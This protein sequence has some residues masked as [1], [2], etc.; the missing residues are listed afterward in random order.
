MIHRLPSVV[1]DTHFREWDLNF[2]C[3]AVCLIHPS[4]TEIIKVISLAQRLHIGSMKQ[5]KLPKSKRSRE[6]CVVR[7]VLS[8]RI[9][10]NQPGEMN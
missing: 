4:V 9:S 10:F 7:A 2:F 3:E 6:Y 5:S 1:F 8:V